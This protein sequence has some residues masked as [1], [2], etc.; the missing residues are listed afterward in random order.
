MRMAKNVTFLLF[1][2]LLT[3]TLYSE[4]L[5]LYYALLSLFGHCEYVYIVVGVRAVSTVCQPHIA[6]FTN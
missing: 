5:D 1:F 6:T 4:M 3:C 2:Y